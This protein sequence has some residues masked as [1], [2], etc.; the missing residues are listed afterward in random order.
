MFVWVAAFL[1]GSQHLCDVWIWVIYDF[2]VEEFEPTLEM[3]N[4]KLL[5]AMKEDADVL[6]SIGIDP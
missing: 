4:G 5:V 3:D 6:L 2:G 1:T